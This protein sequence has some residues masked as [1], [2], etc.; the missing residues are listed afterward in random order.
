MRSTRLDSLVMESA[1]ATPSLRIC[2]MAWMNSPMAPRPARA[3]PRVSS[4]TRATLPAFSAICAEACLSSSIVAVVSW[5]AAACSV[6]LVSCCV[7]AASTWLA[8]EDRRRAASLISR[9]K[10]RSVSITLPKPSSRGP[11]AGG[12]SVEV[13]H[14]ARSPS[15][16]RVMSASMA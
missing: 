16:T 15:R 13:F 7:E 3:A 12:P 9:T 5:M 1:T 10:V 4:A 14:W 11:E 2:C 8:D 6:E